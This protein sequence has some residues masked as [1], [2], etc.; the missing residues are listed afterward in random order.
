MY[1]KLMFGVELFPCLGTFENLSS[2]TVTAEKSQ[3]LLLRTG[4][5]GIKQYAITIRTTETYVII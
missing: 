4:V 1:S 5:S 2:K 3:K